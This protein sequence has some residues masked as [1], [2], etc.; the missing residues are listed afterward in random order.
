MTYLN[1]KQAEVIKDGGK[2]KKGEIV[3][4]S[5]NPFKLGNH[6]TTIYVVNRKGII[7]RIPIEKIRVIVKPKNKTI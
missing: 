7:G 4:I 5:G 1:G 3:I 6:D 2:F